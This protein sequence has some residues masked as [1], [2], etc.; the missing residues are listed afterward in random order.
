LAQQ[1]DLGLSILHQDFELVDWLV[2]N[3][4]RTKYDLAGSDLAP[5]DEEDVFGIDLSYREFM[6]ER[7]SLDVG[8]EE[9]IGKV[10]NLS[11]EEVLVTCGGGLGLFLCFASLLRRNDEVIVPLPNYPPIY[12]VPRLLGCNVKT[13]DMKYQDGFTLS[14]PS[15]EKM[16]TPKTKMVALTNSNNPTGVKLGKK[17]LEEIVGIT[18]KTG[19]YLLVDE[20][21]REFAK[22]PA[23]LAHTLGEHVIS[24][25]SMSKYYGMNDLKVGW[26]L[27]SR[28]LIEKMKALNKWITGDYVSPFCIAAAT[29]VLEN[30]QKFDRRAKI[31]MSDN[32]EEGRRFFKKE[33]SYLEWVEPDGALVCFPKVKLPVSSLHLSRALLQKFG[34]LVGPGEFFECSGHLRIC[35]TQIHKKVM[36]NLQKLSQALHEISQQIS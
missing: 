28:E 29:K 24:I 31:F 33:A 7:D 35:L 11:R 25:N 5:P 12:K 17:E 8:L 2:Q 6:K 4:Q 21:F 32:L 20:V 26:V 23:P 16:I 30:K 14:I 1:D 10:Y 9:T 15:L 18:A 19:T 3:K 22:D 27:S 34:I 36:K 13:L